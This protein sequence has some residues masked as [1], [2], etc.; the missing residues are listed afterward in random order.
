LD[1]IEGQKKSASQD[2]K[3][4]MDQVG[5]DMGR[6]KQVE[7]LATALK[8]GKVSNAELEDYIQRQQVLSKA[9]IGVDTFTAILEQV[10]LLT[11]HDHGKELLQRLSE[12]E[13][14]TEAVKALQSKVQSLSQEAEGLQHKAGLK[15]QLEADIMKLATE[16]ASLEGCVGQLAKEKV[17]LNDTKAQVASLQEK[18]AALAK[19][20][21]EREAKGDLLNDRL[22]IVE[23]KI[24]SLKELGK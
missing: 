24:A 16:R 8:K 3:A 23:Q 6:L 5:V 2:L 20:I 10:K 13:G 7:A 11:Y 14:L 9:G 12:Y 22:A 21:E 4:H 19:D 1:L 18:R 15:G 17:L